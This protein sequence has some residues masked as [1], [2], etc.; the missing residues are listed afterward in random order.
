MS[1]QAVTQACPVHDTL[2][3]QPRPT[4]NFCAAPWIEGVL[5][6]NGDLQACCRNLNVLG[7]W[8]KDGLRTAWHSKAFQ[9]FR[10]QIA[11]GI[12]PDDQCQKCFLNGTARNLAN[13][14]AAPFNRNRQVLYQFTKESLPLLDAAES[15]LTLTEISPA[16]ASTLKT[17]MLVLETFENS[18]S[19][20]H[21][22]PAEVEQAVQKLMVIGRIIEAFLNHDPTPPGRS[23][24]RPSAM[25]GASTACFYPT[26]KSSKVRNWLPSTLT[27]LFTGATR[28]LI[29]SCTARSFSA[30]VPGKVLPGI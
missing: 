8:Q 15:L 30:I 2:S 1:E 27:R 6:Q 26:V 17:Y 5:K 12:F 11:S 23:V 3:P 20:L 9:A 16:S 24:C 13:E 29:F 28:S 7:N 14:L 22:Y 10:N 25:P 19:L 21:D 4:G 18:C